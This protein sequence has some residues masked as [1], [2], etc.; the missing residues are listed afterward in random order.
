MT[1][2]RTRQAHAQMITAPPTSALI[3]S[4]DVMRQNAAS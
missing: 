3:E 1:T 4:D 2:R